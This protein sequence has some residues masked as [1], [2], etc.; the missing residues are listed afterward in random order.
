[1]P[2]MHCNQCHHEFE[3]IGEL[4]VKCDWCNGDSHEIGKTS[5]EVSQEVV[6]TP[7]EED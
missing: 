1:M 7:T 3:H 2:L 5:L 4:P 6:P